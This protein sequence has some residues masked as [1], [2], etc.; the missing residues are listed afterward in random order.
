MKRETA[1]EA[2]ANHVTI[3]AIITPPFPSGPMRGD[4][5]V[6]CSINKFEIV[7]ILFVLN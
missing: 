4:S 3:Q 5:E 1:G 7:I 6:A 2:K